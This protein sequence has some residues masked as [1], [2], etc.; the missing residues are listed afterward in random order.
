MHSIPPTRRTRSTAPLSFGSESLRFSS[1]W[2]QLQVLPG[3][4]SLLPACLG[5]KLYASAQ[6]WD[7]CHLQGHRPGTRGLTSRRSASTLASATC[8]RQAS[9]GYSMGCRCSP[10][11]LR[12]GRLAACDGRRSIR[13]SADFEHPHPQRA[14]QATGPLAGLLRQA[15]CNW[16]HRRSQP[17]GDVCRLLTMRR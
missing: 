7:L 4:S 5:G 12:L 14:P 13:W 6:R 16:L 8:T 3:P 1:G 2:R 10:C 15:G 11:G 17:P 9:C